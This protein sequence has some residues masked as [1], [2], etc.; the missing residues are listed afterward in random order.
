MAESA[1][2]RSDRK[3]PSQHPPNL[4]SLSGSQTSSVAYRSSGDLGTTYQ[5]DQ[6]RQLDRTVDIAQSNKNERRRRK[7]G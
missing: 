6:L 4:L 2:V 1:L 3:D 5:N 7:E